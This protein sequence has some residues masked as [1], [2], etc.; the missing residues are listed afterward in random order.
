M[1]MLEDKEKIHTFEQDQRAR[2]IVFI[3][4]GLTLLYL[5][6]DF[7]LN[8]KPSL[9]GEEGL[10]TPWG[11]PISGITEIK[12]LWG[13]L[14]INF[15]FLV[16]LMWNQ[17]YPILTRIL[18]VKMYLSV[19]EG[20]GEYDGENH[21]D[22]QSGPQ[23]GEKEWEFYK[24]ILDFIKRLHNW[25]FPIGIPATMSVIAIIGLIFKLFTPHLAHLS[26]IFFE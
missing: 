8:I 18:D 21:P 2:R 14:I 19:N 7:N 6:G 3:W 26:P 20:D 5:W 13:L 1:S 4:S 12:F 11:I 10:V 22:N 25:V 17:I 24:C 16:R 15:I 9:N 23:L